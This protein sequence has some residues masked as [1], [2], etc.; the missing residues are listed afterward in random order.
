MWII[1][2]VIFNSFAVSGLLQA[3]EPNTSQTPPPA[4]VPT[5]PAP[6]VDPNSPAEIAFRKLLELDGAAQEQAEKW[7]DE[8][9][10][11]RPQPTTV[12]G[13]DPSPTATPVP[14]PPSRAEVE[15]RIDARM[16]EVRKEYEKFV[17]SYPRHARGRLA[18]GSFLGDMGE[19]DAS[20]SQ[21]QKALELDPTQ[22]AAWN[23]LANYYA[24]R[25]PVR[26]AFEYF[27]KAIELKPDEPQYW[28]SLGDAVFLFR[29]D[30]QEYWNIDEPKVFAK[31]FELYDRAMQLDPRNFVLASDVAQG[32]YALRPVGNTDAERTADEQRIVQ[33][34]LQSWTNAWNLTGGPVERE[35]V[36]VHFARWKIKERKFQEARTILDGVTNQVYLELRKRL[37]RNISEREL[38]MLK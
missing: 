5:S 32:Y 34:A 31:A 9:Q 16:N 2:I 38:D 28:H 1:A 22:P 23:N 30:A 21:W 27:Q 35:G 33:R 25:G 20:V 24:H 26:Q 6:P 11:P 8:L 17:E 37:L 18:Y 19:E 13:K 7:Q 36:L 4:P 12:P 15:A 10:Q 3:A 29:K 14:P